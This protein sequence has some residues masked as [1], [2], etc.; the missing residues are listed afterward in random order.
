MDEESNEETQ[1][2][3]VQVHYKEA[4]EEPEATESTPEEPD[5]NQAEPPKTFEPQPIGP[6]FTPAPTKKR[7]SKKWMIIVP[8]LL[9]L[10]IGSGASAYYIYSKNMQKK[11]TSTNKPVAKKVVTVKTTPDITWIE[12]KLVSSLDL[13]DTV[14]YKDYGLDPATY[15]K[16]A[17]TK[18][19]GE[20]YL[21][22]SGCGIGSCFYRF[23]QLD[24]TY[25][26]LKNE[27]DEI[28]PALD[29]LKNTVKIDSTTTYS[30]LSA[31]KTITLKD[32]A[33]FTDAVSHTLFSGIANMQL[34]EN[35]THGG[36]YEQTDNNDNK[37][38]YTY[39]RNFY[40][41]LADSTVREYTMN[42]GYYNKENYVPQVTIG[43]VANTVA[44]ANYIIPGCGSFDSTVLK[45][46]KTDKANLS[47]IGTA[48]TGETVYGISNISSP[49]AQ[50]IYAVYKETSDEGMIDPS[51]SSLK[52]LTISQFYAL[53]PK[54]V[55]IVPD[56]MGEYIVFLRN[57]F[58]GM[59]GCGKPVIYL[60]PQQETQVSVRVGADV[61]VSIPNYNQGWQVT[62]YPNGT[63]ID[64]GQTFDSLFWEGQG[65]GIYPKIDKGF[66]VKQANLKSTLE[67][68]LTK[69]GLNMKER[70]DFVSFWMTKLPTTPYVRLSWL[71]TNDMNKIAP[72]TIT[73][74]P[75]T[76]IRVF[77][78]YQGLQTPITIKPQSLSSIPREGFTVIEWGGLKTW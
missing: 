46:P 11:T 45:D 18:D 67:S 33:T 73:P 1:A 22:S 2:L 4:S 3:K 68:Q 57:E 21:V 55:F 36:F 39:N 12:P 66:V 72:L 64:D 61:T 54:P 43:G 42:L 37:L 51:F 70:S 9:V 15:Y 24:G 53:N 48:S 20:I 6:E 38:V 77:L 29:Y 8:V 40:L 5:L 49:L 34:L 75:Q 26:F 19:G 25:Y 27:S 30:E 59:G 65:T 63:I 62:A 78:D 56:A 76:V 58:K 69:L 74:T 32:G 50:E 35:T 17:D 23:K 13:F 31:P 10:I 41:K 14:K 28:Y 47:A 52:N 16:V 71:M 7:K 44:Y 60:Y